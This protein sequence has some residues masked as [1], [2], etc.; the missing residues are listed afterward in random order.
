MLSGRA[1]PVPAAVRA[2]H[3]RRGRVA[4]GREYVLEQLAEVAAADHIRR[5]DVAPAVVL[6][7][8]VMKY[9]LYFNLNLIPLVQT[10]SLNASKYV[11][12]CQ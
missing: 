10:N 1:V 9:V 6:Q 11:H 2:V 7:V 5:D 3:R 12:L 8:D 4:R